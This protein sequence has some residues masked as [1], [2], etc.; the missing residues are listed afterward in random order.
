MIDPFLVPRPSFE[1]IIDDISKDKTKIKFP[2]RTYTQFL[3]SPLYQMLLEDH[4]AITDHEERIHEHT[5]KEHEIKT[6]ASQNGVTAQ[7]IRDIR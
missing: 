4:N 2:D 1:Q 6:T 5:V 7:E 3:D